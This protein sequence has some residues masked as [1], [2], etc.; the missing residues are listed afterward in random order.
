MSVIDLS[1]GPL[2]WQVLYQLNHFLN[3]IAKYFIKSYLGDGRWME[4][5][6]R[7]VANQLAGLMTRWM[8]NKWMN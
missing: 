7:H 8:D 5:G 6:V 3:P 2:A 4:A 1:S